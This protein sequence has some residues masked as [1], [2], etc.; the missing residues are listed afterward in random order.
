MNNSSNPSR[1]QWLIIGTTLGFT[2]A[3]A[4]RK[5][6]C[7]IAAAFPGR[8]LHFYE[9]PLLYHSIYGSC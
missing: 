7:V 8:R 4:S 9:C 5:C 3:K 1:R 6:P 2:C